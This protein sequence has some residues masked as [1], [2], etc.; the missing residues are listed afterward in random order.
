MYYLPRFSLGYDGLYG[1]DKNREYRMAIPIE[2]YI[3][4]VDGFEG[5]GNFLSKFNLEIRDQIT[6]SVSSRSFYNEVTQGIS[7]ERPREGDLIFFPQI[8]R[9]F[10]IRYTDKYALFAPL[11]SLPLYDLKCEMFEYNG[12]TFNTGVFDIDDIYT[13]YNVNVSDFYFKVDDEKILVTEDGYPLL[14]QSATLGEYDSLDNDPVADNEEI[15]DMADSFIDFTEF[16]PFSEG[17]Y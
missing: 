11:G 4:S 7:L 12:E 13:N 9:L 6:L 16:D 1:E 14:L 15:Q 5:D 2:M 17:R 8:K 10:E 3:K